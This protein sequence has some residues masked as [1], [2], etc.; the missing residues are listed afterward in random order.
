[1]SSNTVQ[2]DGNKIVIDKK[3]G[4][5]SQEV[6]YMLVQCSNSA[7]EVYKALDR[8]GIRANVQLLDTDTCNKL[9]P[10]N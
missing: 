8:V 10:K 2:L 6:R 3:K 7:D 4:K 9:F 5:R 1:M